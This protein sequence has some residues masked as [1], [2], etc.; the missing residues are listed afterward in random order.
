MRISHFFCLIVFGLCSNPPN[1]LQKRNQFC[2]RKSKTC[3]FS[4]WRFPQLFGIK[5]KVSS[6]ELVFS[7]HCSRKVFHSNISIWYLGK[8]YSTVSF[9]EIMKF[10]WS[11]RGLLNY[12]YH[13]NPNLWKFVAFLYESYTLFIF[14]LGTKTWRFCG[15]SFSEFSKISNH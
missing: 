5:L 7:K 10:F 6:I 14:I 11:S 3:W 12:T 4:D 15:K 13:R 9:I 8:H 1:R 2:I